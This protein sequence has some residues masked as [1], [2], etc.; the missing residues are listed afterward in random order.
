ML[1]KNKQKI[2]SAEERAMIYE[3]TSW[4]KPRFRRSKEDK[5]NCQRFDENLVT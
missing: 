2:E 3:D 5:D 1:D 4:N